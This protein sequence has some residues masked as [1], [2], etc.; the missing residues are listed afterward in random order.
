[1]KKII[2]NSIDFAYK[3]SLFFLI[4][5]LILN[6]FNYIFPELNSYTTIGIF[7]RGVVLFIYVVFAILIAIKSNVIKNKVFILISFLYIVFSLISL[8]NVSF[9]PLTSNISIDGLNYVKSIGQILINVISVIVLF[10]ITKIDNKEKE[11][12]SYIILGIIAFSIIFSFI[13]DFY[14][15]VS[16]FMEYDHSNYDVTSFFVDKNTFGLLLF[17]GAIISYFLC[18]S[19]N[20]W[21]IIPLYITMFY[22]VII[23]CKTS[24][25][26]IFIL[27]I[28]ALFECFVLL[29]RKNKK[30]F[31]VLLVLIST[32]LIT[33]CTL[34]LV[35]VGPFKY[36]YSALF[37]EYGL[38]Y[39][40]F[41]VLSDRF[42]N[43]K[44][45]LNKI[46][47]F[48]FILLGYSER[49][50]QLF[51]SSPIDNIFILCLISGGIIKL[52]IYLFLLFVLYKKN[53]ANKMMIFILSLLILYGLMQDYTMVGVSFSSLVFAIIILIYLEPIDFYHLTYIQK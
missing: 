21:F 18:K 46:S 7:Y 38:F 37:D 22:S 41:V 25:L 31:I 8:I 14:S 53:I 42:N 33:F 26:L 45:L 52:L 20:M 44:Q 12:V 35:K 51:V 4:G 50:Y 9:N 49:I 48:P 36:I 2:N 11:I 30:A 10:S 19:K 34:I 27:S 1:M 43:W 28:I 3:Y 32:T 23:R 40:S 24:A 29:F 16:T 39:D 15:I 6:S 47:S 5:F 17:L 13:K